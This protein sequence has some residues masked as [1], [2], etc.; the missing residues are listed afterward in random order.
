M[1]GIDAGGPA[2]L[3]VEKVYLVYIEYSIVGCVILRLTLRLSQ[4]Y[5]LGNGWV[6]ALNLCN[7]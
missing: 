6:R 4:C 5:E 3:G 1:G 2:A 7:N